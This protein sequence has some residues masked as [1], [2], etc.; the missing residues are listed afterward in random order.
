MIDLP[1]GQ[2]TAAEWF[3]LP[4]FW[5]GWIIAGI[6]VA[7]A[8]GAWL[9]PRSGVLAD[10]QP[11]RVHPRV[12][13]TWL[14]VVILGALALHAY[15]FLGTFNLYD[16]FRQIHVQ[17]KV[18][19]LTWDNFWYLLLD[20]H[21]GTN[22]ELMYLSF[23]FNWAWAGRAY[24][25]WYL[26]NWLLFVPFLLC[27]HLVARHLTGDRVAGV[28]AVAF[29]ATSPIT[30][31][32]LCWM[33]ERGHYFGLLFTLLASG[34]Y[35]AY[36]AQDDKR[37][38]WLLGVSVAAFYLSQ[39]CKPIF[40]FLPVSLM[41]FDLFSSRRRWAVMV[42]D[43]LP[44]VGLAVWSWY[45]VTVLG[46]GKGL[47][48]PDYLGGS[49]LNTILQD[50]NLLVEYGRTTFV[51][52]PLGMAPPYNEAAGFFFV[53]GVPMVLVN[54][55]APLA[56][57]I[58]LLSVLAVALAAR[59][60]HGDGLPLLWLLAAGVSVATVMNIPPRGHAATFEYRYTLSANVMT[61]VLLGDLAVRFLRGSL[62]RLVNGRLVATGVVV[63]YLT[64]GAFVTA[65]NTWAWQVSH[66]LWVRNADMYPLWYSSR[67]YAGK[68]RQWNKQ[69]YMAVQH[70]LAAAEVNERN[71]KALHKR[72]GDN[73]YDIERYDLAR[74]HWLIYFRRY[75]KKINDKYLEK[76]EKVGLVVSA[77]GR[78]HDISD[79]V[80]TTSPGA[81]DQPTQ[82]EEADGASTRDGAE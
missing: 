3:G 22:Q 20:N 19:E 34:A 11:D 81:R 53:E 18:N 4:P 8:V 47:I 69:P 23:M 45:R 5:W 51:P 70:L 36:A 32:M 43:K 79:F 67:Y 15:G 1:K 25:M 16:D 77:R 38:W 62:T 48:K 10:R 71:D 21:K 49:L 13:H 59:I 80:R 63:A 24:W 68:S 35:L 39:M 57:L 58:I 7:I 14:I 42:L 75:P 76:F 61:A 64:L 72:L 78:V 55:F 60:R 29:V 82:G 74:E 28:F 66:H 56:S 30:S 2:W 65:Q 33:S 26:V 31:E 52:S 54:G 44:F 40:I 6:A 41:L 17:P 37:R 9:L 73:A 27:V 46:V 12:A 50:F